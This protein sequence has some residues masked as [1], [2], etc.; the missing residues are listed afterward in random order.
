MSALI[1]TLL[2]RLGELITNPATGRLSTSD[3]M[4]LGAFLVASFV[5]VWVTVTGHLEEWHLAAY[6]GAF[7]FQSQA[8]KFAAIKRDKAKLEVGDAVNPQTGA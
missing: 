2:R 1:R 3:T 6:L 4:V 7:V 8:S 5:I